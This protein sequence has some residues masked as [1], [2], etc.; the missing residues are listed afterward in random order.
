[1]GELIIGF[2]GLLGS[3][4]LLIAGVTGSTIASVAKGSP[5]HA[6]AK[7]PTTDSGS[8]AA[9]SA[10]GAATTKGANDVAPGTPGHAQVIARSAAH[11]WSSADWLT[12]IGME[13]GGRST[14]VNPTSGAFGIGQ[15]LGATKAEYAKLGATSTNPLDQLTAMEDY[16]RDKYGSPTAALAHE[17][18]YGWY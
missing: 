4:I 8:T 12:L 6:N 2:M 9:P 7:S 18:T 17:H 3:S 11:G 14:A 10:D 15:F 1:M 5:D 13:S 16:I